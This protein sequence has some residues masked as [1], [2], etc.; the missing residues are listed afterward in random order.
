MNGCESTLQY[1]GLTQGDVWTGMG[2]TGGGERSVL[3][4]DRRSERDYTMA[5]LP[6]P[7]R[8]AACVSTTAATSMGPPMWGKGSPSSTRRLVSIVTGLLSLSLHTHKRV[9][10]ERTDTGTHTIHNRRFPHHSTPNREKVK[11][12]RGEHRLVNA[13]N[14]K[15]SGLSGVEHVGNH[16]QAILFRSA[17]DEPRIWLSPHT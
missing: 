9:K 4:K 3:K 15:V 12:G 7:S 16:Q 5:K 8:S 10:H 14:D 13:E 2:V 17:R 11:Y 1:E 6:S